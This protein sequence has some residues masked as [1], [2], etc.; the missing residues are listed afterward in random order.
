[1]SETTEQ[2]RKWVQYNDMTATYDTGDGTK[3][4][5]E[6]A[7]SAQCFWDAINIADIREKQ[8]AAMKAGR[9]SE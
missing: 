6:L 5:K 3:V 7:D 9:V 4:P 8:R 1:M 2:G